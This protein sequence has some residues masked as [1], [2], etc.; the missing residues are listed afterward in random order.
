MPPGI[1][2]ARSNP[3]PIDFRKRHDRK[4]FETPPTFAGVVRRST[5]AILL[6]MSVAPPGDAASSGAAAALSIGTERMPVLAEPTTILVDVFARE[7]LRDA[8]ITLEASPNVS[9]GDA[10]PQGANV[11]KGTVKQFRWTATPT[12]E[13]L[14]ALRA[15]LAHPSGAAAGQ[16][17]RFFLTSAAETRQGPTFEHVAAVLESQSWIEFADRN[18]TRFAALGRVRASSSEMTNGRLAVTLTGD[19][20]TAHAEG[21]VNET[22]TARM[23]VDGNGKQNVMFSLTTRFEWDSG[24]GAR[25]TAELHCETKQAFPEVG[26]LIWENPKPCHAASGGLPAPAPVY[27]IPGLIALAVFLRR[28]FGNQR[29][30]S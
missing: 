26:R 12:Q 24:V 6:L 16:A 9:L 30:Q 13:G 29:N 28:R 7:E 22:V 5:L 4:P 18:G 27:A 21:P 2:P 25:A 8:V 14:W 11:S 23:L 3:R 17:H 19:G 20:Q 1:A 10:A 15:V